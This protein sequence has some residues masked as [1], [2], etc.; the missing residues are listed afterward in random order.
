M[1]IAG[2]IALVFVSSLLCAQAQI[3]TTIAGTDFPFPPTPIA[4]ANA[5]TG[6]LTGVAVDPAG[7][8]Y[9]GSSDIGNNNVMKVTPQG[10]LTVIAGNGIVGFSGDNGPA[11]DAAVYSP[12][13]ITI[14]A[15]GDIYFIDAYNQ[16]VRIITPS[17]LIGTVAGNGTAGYSGDGGSSLDASLNLAT[18]DA[19]SLDAGLAI[20]AFGDLFIADQGNNSIREVTP[21]GLIYT[22][23]GTGAPGF[24]GDGGPA[25]S[26]KLSGPSGVAVDTAG[27]LYIADTLNNC[28]RKV[29][30]D[31][32]IS[33]F[34]GTGALNPLGDGGPATKA[35]I[36]E[37]SSVAVDAAGNVYIADTLNARVRKVA[38]GGIISTVAGHSVIGY[39]GDGGP[40][41]SAALSLIT[42][43]AVDSS[44][45]LFIAD[46]AN[47][48]V[49]KVNPSGIISTFVGNGLFRFSGDGGPATSA[50][51]YLPESIAV[52]A[53]NNIY[54]AD[55]NNDRIRKIDPSGII[56]TVAGSGTLGFSGDKGPATAASM[57]LPFAVAVDL[58]GNLFIADT[59]N[60]RIRMV[61]PSG[62]ITTYAGTGTYGYTGD[63]GPA[64]SATLKN[65]LGLA[66]DASGNLYIADN[67]NSVI[68]KVTPSGI[69]STI[70]GTG[71]A[72]FSG[73]GGPAAKAK[74]N[75]PDGL[76]V[77]SAGDLF[78]VDCGNDLIR[79]VTPDGVISTVA[80][81]GTYGFS[82]DG[83]PATSAAL[84]LDNGTLFDGV[85]VDAAG[86][87]FF[88][89][90]QN[91]RIRRVAPDGI[92]STV[93]GSSFYGYF[94]DGGLAI[95]AELNLP[96]S[97]ALDSAGDLILSDFG[98]HIRAVLASPPAVSVSPRQL[99]F[100]AS[101][102][103]APA[104]PQNLSLTS[105][106]DGLAFSVSVPAGASWLQVNPALGATPRLI[107]VTA[108]PAGLSPM[109]YQATLTINIPNGNPSAI[110]VPVSFQVTSALPAALAL[111]KA[112]LSFPFPIQAASR[113]QSITVSNIGGGSLPF[114]AAAT[115][116]SGGS[117]LAVTP[118]S[119]QA[120]PA[121]PVALTVTA[122]PAGLA[123]GTYS[124]QVTVSAGSQNQTV[125][126]TMTISS[127]SQAILLSQTGLSFL[128]VQGGGVV[129]AQSFAVQNIGTGVI[130][131]TTSTTT[132][133]GGS[134]WLQ[135]SPA[136]GSS[137]AAADTSPRVF[138]SV[139]PS[140]LAAG[141]YYG[142][143][144]VYAPGAANTPQ[145]V[146]VFL[147]V[148]PAN[149]QVSGVVQPAQLVFVGV[150]GFESP[151]SQTVEVYN[152]AAAPKSFEIQ[153]T[154]NVVSFQVLPQDGTLDPQQPTS[155]VI[156]PYTAPLNPGIYESFV[157][158]RFS[159]G[160][161][162]P[163]RVFTF[164][165]SP[166]A[167]SARARGAKVTGCTPTKLLPALTTLDQSF[168]V[169][170][171]WPTALS[172]FVADDCGN[173]LSSSGSV[174]VNFSDGEQA[175]A[176]RA[177]GAG[178]FE[179]TW[180]TG[181][182]F[183]GVTL[184]VHAATPD[185]LTGDAQVTGNLASQEQPPLFAGAG[186]VSA[187][188]AVSYTAL[189][190]GSAISIYGTRLAESTAPAAALPL[191]A[192]LVDTQVFVTGATA[193]GTSTGL[194]P[195]PLYYVSENQ[196]NALI[197]YEVSVDT[198]LQLLIQRG[199]TLSSPVQIN[200]AQAQPAVFSTTG[201]PGSPGLIQVYPSAGGAP[202]FSSSTAP[203]HPGDTIVL[204]CTGLGPVNPAVADGAPP[205]QQ[206]SNTVAKPQLSV[207]GQSASIA[208]AGLT[209]GFV[210][211]YQ[212]N[213]VLP[214]G[215][216][217]GAGVPVTLAV[218]G[219]TSPTVTLNIQ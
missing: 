127:V 88:A 157:T 8:L 46:S 109:T 87:V 186:I 161:I 155:I 219:Q 169:S 194:I 68:R 212:V 21:E 164:V 80:G 216:K 84:G 208:F 119:G 89:D 116:T 132:L 90:R 112:S 189:A 153:V 59:D 146:T 191:P 150:S 141:A 111:D 41:T 36:T 78:I 197:P 218:S 44:G 63:G 121:N 209:P 140:G 61:A 39:T 215:V 199:S 81:N 12:G 40:A 160:T 83:G 95:N 79:M 203:A 106:V 204:Y 73:D 62:I 65:P 48:R 180:S 170:A 171:G 195:A 124:G 118:T 149:S 100:T 211:L 38:P 16:R 4:A 128:A 122:N 91:N 115:T 43:L 51:F 196:V 162:S 179:N 3:I 71:T 35:A 188:A 19:V 114:T 54:V 217:T 172:A 144:Q 76:A 30:A 159:D 45:N 29:T 181:N 101:S 14:D 207:G 185:G 93:A 190:P 126:V 17:G 142:L 130:N 56:S 72:G 173:V 77:D 147:Q 165:F 154:S 104:N 5:P 82:G 55:T 129:P 85:A 125:P 156:Q 31:G 176:L 134:Q 145:V 167:A 26:A 6:L 166:E 110:A 192:K 97:V 2:R 148:L 205:G 163:I 193:A 117:W 178:N 18:G 66:T 22:V 42:G 206:L 139:N 102:N 92:I 69:I 107:Q 210:G 143:V 37:P 137:D 60:N 74:L 133:S 34:A 135:A 184:T 96:G 187:A 23:A 1:F 20:D 98:N 13:G 15:L 67:Q 214:A 75:L 131:W 32:T 138:V 57:L 213:A 136:S 201:V 202:Y 64:T 123:A 105:P 182:S 175:L 198:S 50:T 10:V 28:I 33:T 94:G 152:I 151:G 168:T 11:V 49:R 52:D 27:N 183:S 53:M 177:Q 120:L 9:L 70:A 24:S 25:T 99:Q 108:D 7:N 58:A 47:H 86:N 200:M 158:L 113:T 174:T 103:G